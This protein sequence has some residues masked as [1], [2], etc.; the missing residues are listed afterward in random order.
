MVKVIIDVDDLTYYYPKSK[1]PALTNINLEIEEGEFVVI[2]GPSGGGK[3]TLCKILTGIIPHLYGGEIRGRV[4][5]DGINVVEEGPRSIVGLIGAVFQVPENQI[6]NLV[7]EEELAFALENLG[8]EPRII[9]ERI[10]DVVK[11]LEIEHLRR[12]S[13]LELSGGEAQKVLIASAL[14]LKPKI[15]VLDEPLAHLDPYSGLTLLRLL[16][17][18]HEKEKITILV[19]EHRLS[20]IV[21]YA[22]KLVILNKRIVKMG[23]P[24]KVIHELLINDDHSIEVPVVAELSHKLG[25]NSIALDI[26]ELIHINMSLHSIIN[27]VH[28]INSSH[29]EKNTYVDSE[30]VI[31]V[32]N[33]WYVYPNNK[34][35]LKNINL[36]IH[37]GEIVA[38]VGANG[39]GKTTLLKH[40]NGLLKPTRGIVRIYG[41]DTRSKSVAELSNFVG[42]VF[43]NPL[44]QFFEE[45][46]IDEVL[47]AAKVRNIPDAY[48]KAVNLLKFLGLEHC[49]DKSPFELSVGEQRRLAIA[50]VLVYDPPI[51]VF[52]EPTAG[53]DKGWKYELATLIG[54]LNRSGKTIILATHDVEFLTSLHV[55]KIIVMN[56]GEVVAQGSPR[57]ILY[58]QDLLLSSRVIPPQ[59]VQVVTKLSLSNRF[60]PMLTKEFLELANVAG[61]KSA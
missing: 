60:R 28:L 39:A 14:V 45:R 2:G 50:S 17:E 22:D 61:Y 9:R 4:Y 5:V 56:N 33:L 52:D 23:E 55:S 1:T 40:F 51:L 11:K 18:L 41:Y 19:F 16:S 12:R 37:R 58:Q 8:V 59:I 31:T 13:T 49:I 34:I 46:V 43:Q 20:N 35:A 36:E 48:E 47:V 6:I 10:N 38:L 25:M 57:D 42:M 15:L 44:H 27:Q 53:L 32:S 21:K 24:R 30:K 29:I 26:D 7:V 54:H 3:S